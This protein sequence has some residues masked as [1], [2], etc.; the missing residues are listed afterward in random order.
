MWTPQP[1]L[2]MSLE[3]PHMGP[4]RVRHQ[5][6][7]HHNLCKWTGLTGPGRWCSSR[8]V[9][10][11][12]CARWA[13]VWCFA[14]R[15]PPCS[16]HVAQLPLA[17]ALPSCSSPK[18][19]LG[20]AGEASTELVS[21]RTLSHGRAVLPPAHMETR[22]RAEKAAGEAARAGCGGPRALSCGVGAVACLSQ[23]T[24][25]RHARLYSCRLCQ[26]VFNTRLSHGVIVS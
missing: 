16:W 18:G 5:D 13:P 20:Q 25:A 8:T 17:Q 11:P 9:H 4:A 24:G 3:I 2:G 23:G 19:P 14:Q 7:S 22:A 1:A 26:L 21:P 10:L 12:P 6:D 15:Q